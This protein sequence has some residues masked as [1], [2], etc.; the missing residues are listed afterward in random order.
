MDNF[1]P[2]MSEKLV[3]YLDGELTG[4][5]Q[6]DLTQ[7]LASDKELQ[8][9]LDNLKSIREAVR[10]YGLQQRVS[11]IHTQMMKE[12]QAAAKKNSPVRRIIRY[13]IAVAASVILI[14]AAIVGYN[15]YTLSANKL[16]ASN[17]RPYELST[18]RDNSGPGLSG[19]ENDYREKKY[20]QVVGITYDRRFTIKEIFL[21]AISYVELKDNTNA[22]KEFKKVIAENEAAKTSF[23]KE[24]AEYYLAL[25]YIRNKDYDFALEQ[26]QKIQDD[27][28]HLYH[29][30]ITGKLI[31]KVK[32]LKW[33]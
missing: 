28:N 31:H 4:A 29:E 32:M 16:F 9:E 14:A 15:F 19:L 26:L 23:F 10:F 1:T 3:Q 25:T 20:D 18:V 11:G 17:Y 6:E 8:D 27:P 24:E 22:I 7:Q 2:N 5:E 21:R 30:K 13:S 33:R 12:L